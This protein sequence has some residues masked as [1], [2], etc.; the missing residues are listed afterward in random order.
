MMSKSFF[1]S[2]WYLHYIYNFDFLYCFRGFVCQEK[3]EGTLSIFQ[4]NVGL[5]SLHLFPF[6][7]TF[8]Y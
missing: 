5:Q 7:I 1:Y 2:V 3:M 4:S 6:T 8:I